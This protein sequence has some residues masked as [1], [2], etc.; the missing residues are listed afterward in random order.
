VESVRSQRTCFICE[1][2]AGRGTNIVVHTDDAHIA[3]LN[4]YPTLFGYTL[5]APKDH[6]VDV[7]GSFDIDRYL[8]LQ[9]FLFSV[10][11][12]VRIETG[13]ERMYLLSLGSHQGNAHVH[14]HVAPL[15]PN[16]PYEMQ[17]FEALRAENGVLQ[18]PDDDQNAFARRVR[19]RLQMER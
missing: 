18:V 19:E 3:F 6:L 17:Q 16:T 4:R 8:A 1:I 9:R 2:V 10:S 13:A 7:T 15:P 12:A 5:V 14:W 11:E